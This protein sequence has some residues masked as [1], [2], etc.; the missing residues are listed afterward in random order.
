M[1]Y[2]TGV[3]DCSIQLFTTAVIQ[4]L[5]VITTK[6]NIAF[7]KK[8]ISYCKLRKKSKKKQSINIRSDLD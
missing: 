1:N 4:A 6:I 2:V 8:I 7:L 5:V 3:L